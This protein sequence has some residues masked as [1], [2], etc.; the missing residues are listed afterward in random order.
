M[1]SGTKVTDPTHRS[2][3]NMNGLLIHFHN[4]GISDGAYHALTC[5]WRH[6]EDDDRH[7]NT[8]TKYINVYPPVAAL[9]FI[10]CSPRLYEACR[11]QEYRDRVLGGRLWKGEAGF[12]IPRW[13]FWRS[14]FEELKRS[15]LATEETIKACKA[16]LNGM[17]AVAGPVDL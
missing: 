1:G 10:H 6:L 9:W 8:R 14:R 16:A 15:H 7:R 17:D 11:N 2:W 13:E 12:N 4:E 3:R 5:I